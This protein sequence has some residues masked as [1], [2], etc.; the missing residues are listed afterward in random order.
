MVQEA[1]KIRMDLLRVIFLQFG[2][3]EVEA[4]VRARVVYY[5]Q[6]GYYA[7]RVEE[8]LQVRRNLFPTYF[9]V[10]AGMPMPQ[11]LLNGPPWP[12]SKPQKS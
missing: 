3:G 7:L 5:H 12:P 6:V 11:S 2:Y 4:D 9:R 10:L 1:D 8:S